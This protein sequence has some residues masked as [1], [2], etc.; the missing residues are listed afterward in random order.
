MGIPTENNLIDGDDFE[1]FRAVA[2]GAFDRRYSED[3]PPATDVQRVIVDVWVASGAIGN[4]GF[5]DHEPEDMTE[6]AASYDALGITT[7][8]DLIRQAAEIIPS[9]DSDPEEDSPV[10]DQLDELADLFYQADEEIG[11]VAARYIR[12]NSKAAFESLA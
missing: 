12:E 5:F 7:A 6:W 9:S 10:W 8:A 4:R 3:T 11:A 2:Q 1:L